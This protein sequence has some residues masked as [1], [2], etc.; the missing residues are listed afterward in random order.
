MPCAIDM[1]DG[2]R[3]MYEKASQAGNL[4]NQNKSAFS[5]ISR[6]FSGAKVWE[7]FE[8]TRRDASTLS[9]NFHV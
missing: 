5:V 1:V 8:G 4:R 6:A 2:G 7:L 3:W 9:F